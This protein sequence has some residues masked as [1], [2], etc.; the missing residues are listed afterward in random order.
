M[1]Y[2]VIGREGGTF[3]DGESWENS[4]LKVFSSDVELTKKEL[5]EKFHK[6]AVLSLSEDG[7][8]KTWTEDDFEQAYEDENGWNC[9]DKIIK[10]EKPFDLKEVE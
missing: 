3:C 8:D 2:L 5:K 10:S 7:A 9:V 4:I 6:Q 1:N